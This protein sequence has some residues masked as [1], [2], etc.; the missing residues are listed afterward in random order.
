MFAIVLLVTLQVTSFCAERITDSEKRL[1][2][3]PAAGWSVETKPDKGII[4]MLRG[5][6][7]SGANLN[8]IPERNVSISLDDYEKLSETNA[9]RDSDM[10]DFTIL[11]RENMQIGGVNA[12]SWVYTAKVGKDKTPIKC[13][14]VFVLN[15]GTAY[16]ITCGVLENMYDQSS[17]AFDSMLGSIVWEKTPPAV[18]KTPVGKSIRVSDK[19]KVLSLLMP[20]DWKSDPNLPKDAVMLLTGAPATSSVSIL[21][22]N[23]GNA[24]LAAYEKASEENATSGTGGLKIESKS[25]TM[26]NGVPASKWVYTA[27]YGE[28]KVPLKCIV[29]LVVRKKV[30][31]TITMGAVESQ[32]DEAR[33]RFE[34][35]IKSIVWLK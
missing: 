35:F 15:N 7:N 25:S 18:K 27:L 24:T 4:L 10:F 12:G 26:V 2:L 19:N 20:A 13:K 3:E 21:K 9:T 14:V 30:A 34:T 32:F 31:Y 11:T 5:P 6:E 22:E 1:T 16:V 17:A 8:I 33:P 29:L 23:V 28:Q